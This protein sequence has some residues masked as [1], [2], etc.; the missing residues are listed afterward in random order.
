M[1]LDSESHFRLDLDIRLTFR[2]GLFAT[3][4]ERRLF[5]CGSVVDEAAFA[6]AHSKKV[7]IAPDPDL[8]YIE[9]EAAA[10]GFDD[11]P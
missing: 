6:A 7:S 5:T 4:I 9:G 3:L 10:Q 2:I 11:E 8:P 1:S